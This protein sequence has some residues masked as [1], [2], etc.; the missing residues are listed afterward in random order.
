[1]GDSRRKPFSTFPPPAEEVAAFSFSAFFAYAGSYTFTGDKVAHHIEAA[2]LQILVN[3]DQV[4]SV[5]L[6]GDRLILR[7]KILVGGVMPGNTELVWERMKAN[8]T[9]VKK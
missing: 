6:E 4:R 2:S 5:K 7:G 3:T 9:D 8:A 1:M